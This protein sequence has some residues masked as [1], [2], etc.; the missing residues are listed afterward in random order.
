MKVLYAMEVKNRYTRDSPLH[1]NQDS[2]SY[3]SLTWCHEAAPF[4]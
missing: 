2:P 4:A 1:N 3:N